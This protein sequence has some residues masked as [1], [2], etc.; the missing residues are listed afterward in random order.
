[1]A[2]LITSCEINPGYQSDHSMLEINL[3]LNSFIRGLAYGSSTAIYCIN[4]IIWIMFMKL[5]K[6]LINLMQFACA[7]MDIL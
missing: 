2:D 4:K 6:K 1:M 5:L 3:I 7:H